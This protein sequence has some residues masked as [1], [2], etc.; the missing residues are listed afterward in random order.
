MKP[1][2][3]PEQTI[4]KRLGQAKIQSPMGK[5]VDTEVPRRIQFS[6]YIMDHQK[7]CD[8]DY[9]F[10][11]SRHEEFIYFD[12]KKVT[13]AIVTCGGLCPGLN[14]VI[15]AIVLSLSYGYGVQ[16]IFG[17][18]F[19]YEGFIADY[20]HEMV[21]L[22]PQKVSDI[23]ELGGTMLGA[24]RGIQPTDQIVDLLERQNINMLFTIGGDGTLRAASEISQEIED[25]GLKISVIG[26]PKTIDNDISYTSQSFG[27]ET[28]VEE[29]CKT[30]RC[31]HVEASSYP[32]GIGLV[33]LMGRNSGFIAATAAIAQRDVNF[34]LIPEV[35]FELD[36]PNGFLEELK[37]RVL[38]KNHAVIVVAEGAGQKY[39]D[40]HDEKDTSGNV[41][42]RNIGHL[43]RDRIADKFKEEK[44][45]ISMK[46]FDPSYI[47]RSVPANTADGLFCATLGQNAVHAAMAGKT[48]M[49]VSIWHGVYCQI[50]VDLAI[51]A[52]KKINPKGSEWLNVLES[53]GQPSF[54]NE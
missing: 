14:N 43:L 25:R 2:F 41:K 37:K 31:A 15:R 16:N 11:V 47:I 23:H 24:S 8:T 4:V 48:N 53:T 17:M 33:K 39:F 20:G 7:E 49:V 28:A 18:R 52:K 50:P 3:T 12:P 46:Y 42:L 38:E 44:I 19:G 6:P 30:I 51:S 10:E 22:D 13:A 35:D 36:G 9:S 29:A 40:E 34:V 26:I 21:R 5:F 1:P 27:F 45:S 32:H 54:I